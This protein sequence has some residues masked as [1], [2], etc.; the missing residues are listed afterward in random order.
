MK[1]RRKKEIY[2]E[3]GKVKI[4]IVK[5]VAKFDPEKSEANII[6]SLDNNIKPSQDK[7]KFVLVN[8][9]EYEVKDVL[10]YAISSNHSEELDL[11]AI[12]VEGV[13][14]A[15]LADRVNK[16]SSETIDQIGVCHVMLVEVSQEN[17]AAKSELVNEFEPYVVIPLTDSQEVLQKF[18]ANLGVSVPEIQNYVTYTASE[19]E[20]SEEAATSLVV[21]A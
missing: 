21:L 17:L 20:S 6:I 14:V 3:G 10:I 12:D 8:P 13:N 7:N 15:Y 2:L 16:L 9:G 19:F 11:L 1:I 5:D 18:A 4:A